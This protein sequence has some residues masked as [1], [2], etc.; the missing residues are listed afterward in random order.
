MSAIPA[1]LRVANPWRNALVALA[2]LLLA[3]G[4]L[5][6][7]TAAV[8]VDIWYRSETF[9]HCF[10]V[11]PITLWLVWRRR[12]WLASIVPR[13]QPFVLIAMAVVAATWLLAQLGT[14]NVVAQF[15]FVTLV[16]LAVPAV[17]GFRVARELMF[18]LLFLY[19]GVPFGE[20]LVPTLMEWTADFTVGALQLSGVPVFREGQHFIIPS[21]NWSVIDECSGVRYVM[22]SFMVGTLFAY[23]NYRSYRRRAA[24]ML[25]ALLLPV[26]ANWLRAYMIV[27]LAHLSGNRIATGVDHILYGWVFFGIVVF[28]MFIIGARWSQPDEAAPARGDA[29]AGA[30][31]GA[32]WP[33]VATAVGAAVIVLLPRVAVGTIERAEGLATA[34]RLELPDQLAPG[35][36]AQSNATLPA[37]TP[38]FTNPSVTAHRVYA[39][40]QGLVGLH[41]AYFRG[42]R[43]DHKLVSSTN[44]LV[45]MR[46]PVWG[47][48]V[49]STHSLKIGD[50]A[51][52]VPSAEIIGR[53]TADGPGGDRLKVWRLYWVD[54]QFITS[55]VRAKL[56]GMVSRL[57]GHGDE[58]ALIVLYARAGAGH[59]AE[60]A[61]ASFVQSNQ[62][63]LEALLER[64][65][66]AR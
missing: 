20:F 27:M 32:G 15:A 24:F 25:V 33:M 31:P 40:P 4:W 38:V 39:G 35:W 5:Y 50:V 12:D 53:T 43:E 14:V 21:G 8:M 6:R 57:R 28:L 13:A 17:L 55:D 1:D 16:I 30:A 64:T 54:G 44:R 19:F 48:P 9:A 62:G 59:D 52:S 61:L 18:P 58:G 29:L 66:S 3:I 63:P 49:E 10:L 26:V 42:Q 65:R 51:L 23:L 36:S 45:G 11:L 60:A 37:F 34:P 7:D 2:G 56:A 41:I 46:D 47:L 22:A